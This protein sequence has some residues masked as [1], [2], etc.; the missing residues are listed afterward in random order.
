MQHKK[1][2]RKIDSGTTPIIEK[3]DMIEKLIIDGSVT[4]VDDE[5]KPLKK[6]VYSGDYD[7]EDEVASV[8]NE[9]A[10]FLAKKDGY[11]EDIPN[12]LQAICDKLNTTVTGRR[13]K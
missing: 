12:K 9:M 13:K 5:G 2:V 1:H 8:D 6:F 7:I 3:N 11:G 4:L 10:S